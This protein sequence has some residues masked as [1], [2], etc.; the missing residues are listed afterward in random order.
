MANNFTWA[1]ILTLALDFE[2]EPREGYV[3][4]P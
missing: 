4:G 3:S 2:N 1:E